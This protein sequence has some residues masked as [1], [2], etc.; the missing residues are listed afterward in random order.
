MTELIKG[1][2][3][4]GQPLLI[5]GPQ[6]CLKSS[7]AI[8]AA[9]SLA[10]GT[11]MLGELEVP[12]P[13]RVAV[14]S[15]ES[16]LGA[17]QNAAHR[18]ARSKG[19]ELAS[20]EGLSWCPNVPRFD[21]P[22][23]L[24]ELGDY[25]VRQRV[26]VLF[27]DPAYL[28]MPGAD[29]ANLMVQGELLRSMK[30]VCDQCDAVMSLVHH[31]KKGAS[32]KSAKPL[33]LTDVA[34]AGFPEFAGQWWLLSRRERFVEGSGNHSLW[35][36]AGSREGFSHAYTV[37]ISEGEY[38][39]RCWEVKLANNRDRGREEREQR[40]RTRTEADR[41]AVL[42]ALRKRGSAE[43][44]SVIAGSAGIPNTRAK[45]ALEELI[46]RGVIR[47]AKVQKN[48]GQRYDGYELSDRQLSPEE[49]ALIGID[50][51]DS[52]RESEAA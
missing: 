19:R 51:T 33:S 10:T 34:W 27:I 15:G 23:D 26:E 50:Q 47:R 44:A 25:L 22:A 35:L 17:M 2:M 5:A 7:V 41:G 39:N 36:S 24:D 3:V 43:T 29:A 16:G 1:G 48:N 4:T 28:A 9:I 32:E 52:R 30:L 11:R 6:K 37:N 20:I 13:R 14:M 38:P 49:A 12:E 40:G 21:S 46:G 8:D 31:C 42:A 18:I 45:N